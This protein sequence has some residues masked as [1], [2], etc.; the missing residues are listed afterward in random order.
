M[1]QPPQYYNAASADR[2][3][4]KRWGPSPPVPSQ[5]NLQ[6]QYTQQP[7]SYYNYGQGSGSMAP[8]PSS[9]SF[10]QPGPV[11]MTQTTL[12]FKSQPISCGYCGASNVQSQVQYE[13]GICT[14]LSA[15]VCCFLGLWCG[16][17]C[18][19]FMMDDFK[20]AEHHC[21]KCQRIVGER[22]RLG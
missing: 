16:C 14:W 15:G 11:Y 22:T 3:E 5:P 1:S 21:P 6:S 7:P 12:G 2:S 17:C 10:Q 20:D 13:N 4:E 18:A 19:P 9:G 8:P